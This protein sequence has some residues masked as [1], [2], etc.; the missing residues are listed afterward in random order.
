MKRAFAALSLVVTTGCADK[1][2]D[3]M[4]VTVRVESAAK[5]T[6][7]V[8]TARGGETE[9]KTGCMEVPSDRFLD[10]AILRRDLPR[11]LELSA[12]GFTDDA[13][14]TA[15]SPAET[16]G[17]LTRA[18]EEGKIVTA[19][20][21][22]QRADATRETN[23][24]DAMDDDGDGEIDCADADCDGRACV[25]ENRCVE[26]QT[27]L[28]G[29]CQGG[30][31]VTCDAPPQCFVQTAGVCVVERGCQY[32]PD[33]G[34]G[35]DD[36]DPCTTNDRCASTGSC[37]GT[38]R[39]CDSPPVGVQCVKSIGQCTTDGGCT[40]TIDVD[41]GCDDGDD[42]TRDDVCDVSGAC[43]GHASTCAPRECQ[44]NTGC[45]ADGGCT[46]GPV[47]AGT[48]C[49]N[50]GSCNATGGCLP[51]FLFV[52]SNVSLGDVPTPSSD[53]VTYDC[54]VTEIDTGA[55]GAPT[56]VNACPGHAPLAHASIVQGGVPTLVLAFADLEVTGANTLRLVGERPVIIVSMKNIDVFGT[57][58]VR[59]GAQACTANGAG[60]NGGGGAAG[61]QSGG[62]GG[63]FG[64]VGGRG[65][66]VVNAPDGLGGAVNGAGEFRGGCPGGRGGN[67]PN[68]A[69]PG[70]GALQL[71][72]RETINLSGI[73][74]APGGGGAGGVAFQAGNGG[75]SGGALLLEAE[76]FIATNGVL[77][78]NGGGGGQQTT[79]RDGESGRA[80]TV[81]AAGGNDNLSGG[82]GGNG[83]TGTTAATNG[84]DANAASFA[85]GGG[86]GVGRIHINVS[87]LCDIGPPVVIS[88]A[89]TSNRADAGCP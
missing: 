79:G 3:A 2:A 14:T 19:F 58:D 88:P 29:A 15:T 39:V 54:G 13:C 49:S 71:V 78:C 46:F 38:P 21:V 43:R 73:I 26:G 89:A 69:A 66:D 18:F 28:E 72:A 22:L 62:G 53:K 11:E 4:G 64:T 40:Y 59:A 31:Q 25:S 36:E 17:P 12:Q 77:A 83:A 42:C 61:W 47:D 65:G 48:S 80:S 6:H 35:C 27:C 87:A 57:I 86:G 24:G 50:G 63:G 51:P 82:R 37:S 68:A 84:G 45:M 1:I 9:L 85:G 33:L 16:A 56:V 41:A 55:S 23:C 76:R 74:N 10:I 7:V 44:V 34:M 67:N 81:P 75:G 30:T 8:L 52:P 20:M 32:L 5:S 60:R 70:G